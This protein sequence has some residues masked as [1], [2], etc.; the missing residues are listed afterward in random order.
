MT[1]PAPVGPARFLLS[2]LLAI[3]MFI[4][5][6]RIRAQNTAIV[7]R[8]G[9]D[10][11]AAGG[12]TLLNDVDLFCNGVWQSA[13]GVTHFTGA[14]PTSVNGSGSI[15]LW[16]AEIAKSSG[17]FITLNAG[18]QIGNGL[19]FTRG[20]ID[21]NGQVLRMA[22]TARL[23]GESDSGRITG[24]HGGE[25]VAPP[26]IADAPDH[27]NVGNLGAMLTSAANLGVLSINRSA[28]PA[29]G[30]GIGIQ[31]IYL[32]QPQ[33]NTAL[34]A[35]LRFY[36][37]DAELNGND[38]ARLNLWKSTDGIAWSL[39][40]ADTRDTT[41]HYVEKTGIADLSYWTL[42]SL[43][44]PLPLQ[45]IGFSAVCAGSYAS[46]EWKTGEESQLNDFLVQRSTDGSSWNTLGSVDARNAPNGAAYSFKD[47][48]PQSNCFYRLM[49][50]DRD[51][52]ATYS[53]VFSGGCSDIALPFVVYPNPAVSQVVA[54]VS[55]RKA[56]N[57]KV[58][59][60]NATGSAVY[61]TEWNLRTGLNQL[62]I[63]LSGWAAGYYILRLVTSDAVQ[64]TQF[65]KL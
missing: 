30:T 51:G 61:E 65:I 18:L 22:D 48:T 41:H 31:R 59:V 53:P 23:A 36:Y 40:G 1:E 7:V 57:G 38:P 16:K 56:T 29:S 32:I 20:L 4:P 27:L 26:A 64:T 52:K 5:V 28:V 14:H 33:N 6:D 12:F 8:Q 55:V 50:E 54:R 21:L 17:G 49:I 10:V 24:L 42:A 58:Q 15:Q 9:T 45:L 13:A 37:L 60:M 44:S 34:N 35:T 19:H 11:K 39:T 25:I 3:G 47:V 43:S 2:Y 46:I 63:P 62:V